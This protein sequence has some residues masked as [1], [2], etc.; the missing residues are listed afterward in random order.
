MTAEQR[1]PE[2]TFRVTLGPAPCAVDIGNGS[3]RGEYVN[4][5]YLLRTLKR[6]HRSVN[7]M[8]CYYP[9]DKGWPLRASV[10][11]PASRK[12]AWAY[13]Y[14]D[15]FPY[16]GGP[17]GNTKGEP[18]QQI[19]DIR[20]HGQDVTLTL[21]VDCGIKDS[22]LKT[23]ARELKPFGCLRI[24]IN[25]EC[26]GSWFAFNKRY[27]R[28]Q[29]SAFFIR[30][31][32]IIKSIAPDIQTICCFGS[33]DK[34]TGRL[35]YE[36][37]LAPMLS[38]ADIWSIDKYISL[39]Y[40]WPHN[41]C[42]KDQAN[43]P[44]TFTG[45]NQVWKAMHKIYDIFVE[46]SGM[47]KPLEICELNSDGDVT[48]VKE[49]ARILNQFYNKV[50]KKKPYFLRGITYYQ[51][52]DRG[53]LGLEQEDPN[54]P[55]VGISAPFLDDYCRI[56]KEPYF[57]PTEFWDPMESNESL[58]LKWCSS[59]DADGIGWKI[60]LKGNPT[61]FEVKFNKKPNLIIKVGNEWFYKKPGV[62]WVDLTSATFKLSKG[63]EPSVAVFS[64]PTD[65]T[66]P[67]S[68]KGYR[69]YASSKLKKPP[70]LRVRY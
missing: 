57:S 31:H 38:Y 11:H 59:D 46:R 68:G 63:D 27:D 13:P 70:L 29:I 24:R 58:S 7:L 42:E 6:P 67:R 69:S 15:Y 34:E 14:D 22:K 9:N 49:Q 54:N 45:V 48:G 56:I 19:R 23:I 2:E 47:E 16:Q 21:A 3:E 64:P 66:N 26:D 33:I 12:F 10:A 43:Q 62:E 50:L 28:N 55:D 8:Y 52:R 40:G 51:F 4:Q 65:G 5:D 44:Y 17:K 41:I 60:P 37:E 36:D 61:F 25:H 53:R 20:R 30:F 1:L 39:H 18:F 32:K 35:I